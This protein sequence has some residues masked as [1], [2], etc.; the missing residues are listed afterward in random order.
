MKALIIICEGPT[1]QE[2]CT[3]LLKEYLT[4]V[5]IFTP[6]IKHSGGGIVSWSRLKNQIVHHLNEKD[7]YVTTFIDYYGI[8]DSLLFPHWEEGKNIE[9]KE[10][11][12]L[13]LESAMKDEIPEEVRYR[14]IPHLQLHE[15]ESLLFCDIDVF[16]RIYEDVDINKLQEAINTFNN[17]PEEINNSPST[18]PSKRILDAVPSYDKVIDGN[19]LALE[20][21]IKK[22]MHLCPHFK[23]WIE[24]LKAIE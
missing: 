9:D 19:Y 20:I 13:F 14:F 15:F 16:K 21:G 12:M 24:K 17:H 10:K 8:K 3:D 6:I 1:E 11:R 22:M 7:Y 4:N 18:A 5:T 2:F 23:N